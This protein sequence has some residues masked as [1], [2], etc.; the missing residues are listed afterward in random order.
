MLDSCSLY[1]A[2]LLYDYLWISCSQDSCSMSFF[3]GG[4]SAI[5]AVA[6]TPFRTLFRQSRAP[7]VVTPHRTSDIYLP[8]PSEALRVER[9]LPTSLLLL[10]MLRRLGLAH[11]LIRRE[12]KHSICPFMATA[13]FLFCRCQ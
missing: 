7:Q 11:M 5:H 9:C 12:R 2:A 3:A 10:P 4:N 6:R 1:H 13:S 8:F